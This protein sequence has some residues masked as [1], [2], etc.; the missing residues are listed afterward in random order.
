[1][2]WSELKSMVDE[3]I[4]KESDEKNKDPEIN[5]IDISAGMMA[6]NKEVIINIE[7]GELEIF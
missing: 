4:E 2:K 5:Y 6:V 1:M 7:K 3:I